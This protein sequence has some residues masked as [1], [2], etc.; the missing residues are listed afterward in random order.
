[1]GGCARIG[2]VV[3]AKPQLAPQPPEERLI[4]KEDLR[5]RCN[6]PDPNIASFDV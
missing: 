2:K 3:L 6:L 4:E 5:Q 1:L